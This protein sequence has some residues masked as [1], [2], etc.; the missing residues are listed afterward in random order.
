[1]SQEIKSNTSWSLGRTQSPLTG[2]VGLGAIAICIVTIT[3]CL[4]KIP[5]IEHKELWPLHKPLCWMIVF[6]AMVAIEILVFKTHQRNFD[7]S[8]KRVLDKVAW[9]RVLARFLALII[10]FVISAFVVVPMTFLF[11]AFLPFYILFAP[12]IILGAIPYFILCERFAKTETNSP[13]DEILLLSQIIMPGLAGVSSE[14]EQMKKEH[15]LNLL[16][17]IIIKSY[18]I[19]FMTASCSTYWGLWQ[20][21][22][23][24]LIQSLGSNLHGVPAGLLGREIFMPLLEFTI[25][26]DITI[27]MLGYISSCRLLDTQ[28]TSADPHPSGWIAALACYPPFNLIFETMLL[29][30]VCYEQL[31][32]THYISHPLILN[33]VS[34]IC[35]VLISIYSLA[36]VMFG[37]RFSN[38]TNRGIITSGPYK[39]V[40]H[41]AYIAKNTF[42]WFAM[43]PW[44]VSSGVNCIGSVFILIVL[45]AFYV[46]R[47]LTEEKH[48][49]REEHYQEYCQKVKWRFIPGVF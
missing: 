41:P 20:M 4:L 49:M 23:I 48:L 13:T 28:F 34:V 44:F 47:A 40:R 5:G 14:T 15:M 36:T 10:C 26:V 45:N 19:P 39:I 24:S 22:T 37:L 18:F 1:M 31:E 38:L 32:I 43:M 12:L 30:H 7:F 25:V 35:L 11:P 3:L 42:W 17:G 21:K 8:N 46:W 16:R 29:N 33:T 6:V 2:Y 9:Q 27:A